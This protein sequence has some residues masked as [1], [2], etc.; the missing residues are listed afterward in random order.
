MKNIFAILVLTVLVSSCAKEPVAEFTYSHDRPLEGDSIYF[1]N[2]SSLATYF[3]WD[4]GDGTTSKEESPKK[5]FKSTGNYNVSLKAF[6]E[7]GKKSGEVSKIVAVN[8]F[9][10]P[11][12]KGTLGGEELYY[13]EKGDFLSDPKRTSVYKQNS[14]F[15]YTYHIKYSAKLSNS[16]NVSSAYIRFG[17]LESNYLNISKA[18]FESLF[19]NNEFNVSHSAESGIE[20]ILTHA[21]TSWSTNDGPQNTPG[22]TIKILE[23]SYGLD[24][25]RYEIYMVKI[26]LNVKLFNSL[27]NSKQFTGIYNASFSKD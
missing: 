20:F 26:E 22:N 21:G 24:K 9:A 13:I 11:F 27:G 17:T 18:F 10:G 7:N 8:E 23:R 25:N 16:N 19:S 14:N 6:S 3:E 4:F 15:D 5:A 12:L 2:T 1:Y